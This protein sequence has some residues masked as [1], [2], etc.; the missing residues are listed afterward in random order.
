MQVCQS[1]VDMSTIIGYVKVFWV[2][3]TW[4]GMSNLQVCQTYAGMPYLS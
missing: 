1:Y 2:C 3:Q 4:V